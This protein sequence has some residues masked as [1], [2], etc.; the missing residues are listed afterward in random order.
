M[1]DVCDKVRGSGSVQKIAQV[2]VEPVQSV[3]DNRVSVLF[4]SKGR[5]KRR[6]VV[7]F[8]NK[9]SRTKQSEAD[10]CDLNKIMARYENNLVMA[11]YAALQHPERRQPMYADVSNVPDYQTAMHLVDSARKSFMALPANIRSMFKND[12]AAFLD[13]VTNPANKVEA[14]KLGLLPADSPVNQGA[15]KGAPANQAVSESNDK[16]G[17]KPAE[18]RD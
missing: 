6:R 14:Q 11:P 4:D 7:Q 18:K 12:A 17:D 13:F 16:S 1:S 15:P 2:E 3:L 5:V 9:P 10:A 8:F